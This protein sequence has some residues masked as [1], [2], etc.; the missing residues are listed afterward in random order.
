MRFASFAA[1]PSG[2]P[3][4][5]CRP[6]GRGNHLHRRVGCNRNEKVRRG[7]IGGSRGTADDAGVAE[8]ARRFQ[9]QRQNQGQSVNQTD[10]CFRDKNN[11]GG[12]ALSRSMLEVVRGPGYSTSTIDRYNKSY[13]DELLVPASTFNQNSIIWRLCI[14][15]TGCLCISKAPHACAHQITPTRLVLFD[16]RQD[17]MWLWFDGRQSD[18][19]ALLPCLRTLFFQVIAATNRPDVLDPALLRSGRLDRKIELPHPSEEARARILQIHSRKMNV[20]KSEHAD[21]AL[22]Y[23]LKISR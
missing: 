11:I 2:P 15:E 10:C 18:Q 8:S 22:F 20:D 3:T 21:I 7:T 16:V 5:L 6:L 19:S 4:L 23:Y 1:F 14:S 13:V 17:T 12:A 9:Q